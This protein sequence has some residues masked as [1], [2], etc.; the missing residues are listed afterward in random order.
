MF[1][2]GREYRVSRQQKPKEVAGEG[3]SLV[4]S[5]EFPIGL[6]LFREAKLSS[7]NSLLS[8]E[9]WLQERSR[10]LYEDFFSLWGTLK[11]WVSHL[12]GS[13][14]DRQERDQKVNKTEVKLSG[15]L[16]VSTY[17]IVFTN[18]GGSKTDLKTTRC[19]NVREI[20]LRYPLMEVILIRGLLYLPKY[21]VQIDQLSLKFYLWQTSAHTETYA[22]IEF[23]LSPWG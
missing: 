8:S 13:I 2:L 4:L 22:Y 23:T 19:A 15:L 11:S 9:P 17:L 6:L 21:F 18:A 12:W 1:S 16:S 14:F 3:W 20:L 7:A 10:V 5:P